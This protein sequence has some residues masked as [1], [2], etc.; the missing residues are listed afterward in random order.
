MLDRNKTK[1]KQLNR[2]ESKD[3]LIIFYAGSFKSW[4]YFN[5]LFRLFR[6]C[7]LHRHLPLWTHTFLQ[8]FQS[9]HPVW[10]FLTSCQ[11]LSVTNSLS[12][13]SFWNVCLFARDAANPSSENNGRSHRK[14]R[15]EATCHFCAWSPLQLIATC[16]NH[17]L[18]V[19]QSIVF[20]KFYNWKNPHCHLLY[21][22]W[23]Q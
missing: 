8:F 14:V 13:K 9:L 2:T 22:N 23:S 3:R 4:C 21:W 17:R 10:C 19:N 7:Q 20:K 15:S 11:S 16:S 1:M 12:A 6:F 5:V 18:Q